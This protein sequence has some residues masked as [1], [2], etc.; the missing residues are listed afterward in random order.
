M[1]DLKTQRR[2][3]RG[4][5]NVFDVNGKEKKAWVAI[6]ILDKTDFETKTVTTDKQE[7]YI[8]I[9]EQLSR[10]YNNYKYICTQLGST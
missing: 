9:R 10:R 6:L 8:M 5:K 1:S 2:K 4:W 3:V 7:H